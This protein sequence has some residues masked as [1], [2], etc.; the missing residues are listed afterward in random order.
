MEGGQKR[1][2]EEAI[3]RFLLSW[4][5]GLFRHGSLPR[6]GDNEAD[7]YYTTKLFSFFLHSVISFLI[8]LTFF[9]SQTYTC[10]GNYTKGNY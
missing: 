1:K 6:L 5:N 4:T 7:T 2:R 8:F 9:L 10:E 3:K